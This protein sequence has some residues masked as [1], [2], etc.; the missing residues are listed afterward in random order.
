MSEIKKPRQKTVTIGGIEFT[1]QFPGVRKA[2]QMADESKDR[3]GNLLT[4]KYYGQIMEHVI[5]NPRTNWDF[6]DDH[7]D[8]MEDVFEAAFRFLNNPQ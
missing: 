4:E 1:F 6:W 7:L 8:I 3:Y 5:V 2:L